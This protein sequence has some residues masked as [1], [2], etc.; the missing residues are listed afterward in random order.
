VAQQVY[1]HRFDHR[2]ITTPSVWVDAYT[3]PAGYKAL[4][5]GLTAIN[6]GP[7]AADLILGFGSGHQVLRFS[8]MAPASVV[9]ITPWVVFETGDVIQ[10]SISTSSFQVGI[11]GQLLL[12]P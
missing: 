1:S 6:T 8:A 5:R 11:F 10:W 2:T 4:I 9:Q 12:L 7:S 3:V